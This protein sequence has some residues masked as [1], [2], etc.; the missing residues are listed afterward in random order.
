MG[1]GKSPVWGLW[2]LRKNL[3]DF[4]GFPG[5]LAGKGFACSAGDPGL[6]PGSGRSPGVGVGYPLQY[7]WASH[8]TLA[9]KNPQEMW[10]TWVRSLG[11][12][13]P[14]ETGKAAHSSIRAWRIPWTENSMGSQRVGQD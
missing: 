1:R 11:W 14:L 7:S 10:E 2:S 6:I 9:V 12:E 5:S 8:V 13:D 3:R 4:W